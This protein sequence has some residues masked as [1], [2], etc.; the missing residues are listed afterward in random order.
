MFF[1]TLNICGQNATNTFNLAKQYFEQ[2]NYTSGIQN[3]KS[4]EYQIGANPKT[5]SL[6]IYAYVAIK[7]YT[8]AK[9]ELEKFKKLIGYKRTEPIQ[10]IL[11][12]EPE[13]N[14]GVQKADQ[15]YRQNILSKRMIEARTIVDKASNENYYKREAL[16]KQFT[17]LKQQATT[18]A[19]PTDIANTLSTLGYSKKIELQKTLRKEKKIKRRWEIQYIDKNL[20]HIAKL[21]YYEYNENGDLIKYLTKEFGD[22][23]NTAFGDY[24]L[25]EGKMITPEFIQ[26]I[27][28]EYDYKFC[29]INQIV[30]L[31]KDNFSTQDKITYNQ[32]YVYDRKPSRETVV[33]YQ[34]KNNIGVLIKD[35][36]ISNLEL[37]IN[38]YNNNKKVRRTYRK[39]KLHYYSET[40]ISKKDNGSIENTVSTDYSGS[41]FIT[42]SSFIEYKFNDYEDAYSQKYSDGSTISDI[43]KYDIYG[44]IQYLDRFYSSYGTVNYYFFFNFYEYQDGYTTS[45]TDF[46]NQI[47]ANTPPKKILSKKELTEQLHLGIKNQK[48]SNLPE[49]KRY[50]SICL[51]ADSSNIEYNYWMAKTYISANA[52]EK[53]KNTINKILTLDPS[54][55]PA[56]ELMGNIYINDY[57]AK[58]TALEYY[59]LATEWG[60]TSK[61]KTLEAY[62]AKFKLDKNLFDDES[63]QVPI[64]INNMIF[65][66]DEEKKYYAK[67]LKVDNRIDFQFLSTTDRNSGYGPSMEL[68]QSRKN[69][70]LYIWKNNS[71]YRLIVTKNFIIYFFPDGHNLFKPVY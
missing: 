65:E 8:N 30:N 49:A 52:L 34:W 13:I 28:S 62:N 44:N 70:N 6:L 4:I 68:K 22:T 55:S 3:L 66:Y 58:A 67:I 5:Q 18:N 14:N 11:K 57:K 21:N 48:K 69:P 12:L 41:Q 63:S 50:L 64:E 36:V 27:E 10:A 25:F 60:V 26:K 15:N 40:D 1:V 71:N 56:Y 33:A 47:K 2:G 24:P 38:Q 59:K 37:S 46:N 20:T 19:N 61:I 42:S 45:I 31:K 43:A 32:T 35:S 54:F 7:D 9:I 39:G 23:Y 51:E 53:A 16:N 17:Q 29:T